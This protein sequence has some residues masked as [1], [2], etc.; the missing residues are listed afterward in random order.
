M[1]RTESTMTTV[2]TAL[3]LA[4]GAALLAAAPA[5]AQETEEDLAGPPMADA[6][7][8]FRVSALAGWVGWDDADGAGEQEVDGGSLLGLDLETRVSRYLAFRFGG[9][10]GKTTITG[11]DGDGASQTADANQYL[12]ELTAE[13]R[14]AV[15][16]LA[17]T[18]VV[19]FGIVGAGSV[20]HDPSTEPGE[21]DPSLP[22]RSQ[23]SL[24]LGGGVEVSPPALGGFGLRVEWRRA[25]VQMQSLF[26]VT[27]REGTGRTSDRILGSL[28]WSF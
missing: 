13:P 1:S 18:G 25:E 14:L 28:Y 6:P 7:D 15:G 26:A 19:P 2:R 20:V 4:L 27:A 23:G 5:A 3:S 12:L 11:T 16:P 17:R 21:F 9:G 24:I 22:T 8:Q 10:F